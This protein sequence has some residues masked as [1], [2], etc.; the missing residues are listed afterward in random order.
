MDGSCAVSQ[1]VLLCMKNLKN[2][3][4]FHLRQDEAISVEPMGVL[5]VKAHKLVEQNMSNRSHSHGSAGMAGIGLEG[6][7]DLVGESTVSSNILSR[8]Q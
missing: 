1:R 7:I 5:W 2:Q 8:W 6:G 4:G 3:R